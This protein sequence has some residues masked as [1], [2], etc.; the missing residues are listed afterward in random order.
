M[1][2]DGNN[3][4]MD[5]DTPEMPEPNDT[6]G[7]SVPMPESIPSLP[8]F[9]PPPTRSG[10]ARKFPNKYVDFLPNSTTQLP[11]LPACPP[12]PVAQPRSCL[13]PPPPIPDPAPPP[14]PVI[15]QTPPNVFGLYREY[16]THPSVEI[17]DLEDLE[18]LCDAPG[19]ATATSVQH[20]PWWKAIGLPDPTHQAGIFAPFLNATIYRLMTWF[21]SGSNTKSIGELDHLVKDVILADDFD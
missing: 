3:E 1:Q 4:W 5:V 11:H 15:I 14:P 6:H 10:R 19:I 9:V 21:Y 13:P 17:D 12:R 16:L 18:T 8:I 7:D 2:N 20:K